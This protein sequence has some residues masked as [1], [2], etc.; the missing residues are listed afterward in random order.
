MNAFSLYFKIGFAIS[1]LFF[2]F[3]EVHACSCKRSG[4]I[5]GQKYANF[6]FK[7]KVIEIKEILISE[8]Y[9]NSL[10]SMRYKKY[11]FVFEIQSKLKGKKDWQN[12]S[13]ISVFTTA[14]GADCGNNFDKGKAYL[15]YSYKTNEELRLGSPTSEYMTTSLCTRTKKIRVFTFLETL[16]LTIT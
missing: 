10:D 12:E 16:V 4:I 5:Q 8:P 9:P 11:E 6:V 3:I 7:G 1:I 14:G 2:S 13:R 15:V